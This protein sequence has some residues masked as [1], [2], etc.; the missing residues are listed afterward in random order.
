VKVLVGIVQGFFSGFLI[1]MILFLLLFDVLLQ[2]PGLTAG[3]AAITFLGGWGLSA[4]LLIRG[5]RSV[6]KVFSRG[7]LLGAAEW[8]VMILVGFVMSGRAL[9][10]SSA[11]TDAGRTGAAIGSGLVALVTG[12]FSLFMAIVCLVGFA[13]S[14]NMGR[15]MRT[16]GPVPTKKC[17]F[18]AEFIQPEAIRCRHCSADLLPSAQPQMN[19]PSGS[20]LRTLIRC[21]DCGRD[22]SSEAPSC[23]ECGR[24]TSSGL[25]AA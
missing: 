6:S 2:S 18:C 1:Y 20:G 9:S 5:A 8:M 3:F 19:S 17:P 23:P 14:R 16:E 4:F 21:P 15:E 13:I 12:G 25:P 7:F 24:P 22:V 10:Q 11:A